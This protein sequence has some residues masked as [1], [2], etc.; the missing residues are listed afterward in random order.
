MGL[1]VTGASVGT[2]DGLL[3]CTSDGLELLVMVGDVVGF[4]V[5][6]SV[7]GAALGRDVGL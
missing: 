2:E 6:L 1:E 3:E 5:G 4:C 7:T